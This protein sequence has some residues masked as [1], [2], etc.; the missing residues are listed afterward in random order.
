MA[1]CYG[2]HL[3]DRIMEQQLNNYLDSLDAPYGCDY[4]EKNFS[5]DDERIEEDD[6]RCPDCGRKL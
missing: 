1:G 4:C 6:P 3:F 5:P 2:G